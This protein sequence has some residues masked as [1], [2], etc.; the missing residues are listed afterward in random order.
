MAG[1]Q[2]ATRLLAALALAQAAMP[3]V[4]PARA[5]QAAKAPVTVDLAALRPVDA[6]ITVLGS[7]LPLRIEGDALAAAV[8][9]FERERARFAPEARLLWQV[10]LDGDE[11]LGPVVLGLVTSTG[12][13]ALGPDAAGRFALPARG[14]GERWT[15]LVGNRSRTVLS[16][17]PVVVSP[18]FEGRVRRLGDLRLE[19]RAAWA[20]LADDPVF[21]ARKLPKS[22]ESC[23]RVDVTV[24]F[25]APWSLKRATLREGTRTMAVPVAGDG[26]H[27]RPPL[28][29]L[30][31]SNAARVTLEEDR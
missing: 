17:L 6:P 26:V 29:D 3:Q 30:S 9:V 8:R 4:A 19:C 7:N 24:G 31:W 1:A 27:A 14:A 16:V 18:G 28:A 5:A 10:T 2:I 11:A 13:A 22:P 23:A 25:R 15:M 21:K 12:Q 20:M